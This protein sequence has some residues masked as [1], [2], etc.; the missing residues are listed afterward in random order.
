MNKTRFDLTNQK[1]GRLLVNARADTVHRHSHWKCLCDCGNSVVVQGSYLRA[2]RVTCCGCTR[3]YLGG[4]TRNDQNGLS[5]TPTY[6][7]WSSM[8]LRCYYQSHRSY[9]NYGDMGI[10]VCERWRNS[11]LSFV[12]D[13][14]IRP[15]GMTLDRFP[16]PKGHYEP[17]NCRWATA[18]EQNNNRRGNRIVHFDGEDMTL[19]ELSRRVQ[20][21][22][23]T[24]HDR[25]SHGW[26][27]ERAVAAGQ[28]KERSRMKS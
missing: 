24:L 15:L 17:G 13:M 23:R 2:G 16:D 8:I 26:S 12:E 28:P 10:R 20:V 14:G 1:Y 19:A 4:Y 9:K 11:F 6:K 27:I 25:L 5:R 7:T 3:K 18:I 21:P 22:Y